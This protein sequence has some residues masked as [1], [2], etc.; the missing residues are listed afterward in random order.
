[1]KAREVAGKY[2]R[3]HPTEEELAEQG[4]RRAEKKRRAGVRGSETYGMYWKAEKQISEL[5]KD[6]GSMEFELPFYISGKD[7]K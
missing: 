7:C 4:T 3:E 6:T 1:M 5:R 2:A